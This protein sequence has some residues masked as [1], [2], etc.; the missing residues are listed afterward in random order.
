MKAIPLFRISIFVLLISF[1]IQGNRLPAQSDPGVEKAMI[2]IV[3]PPGLSVAVNSWVDA[4][5]VSNPGINFKVLA[6]GS[7]EA[8]NAVPDIRFNVKPAESVPGQDLIVARDMVV[9]IMHAG[10]PGT[11]RIDEKGITAAGLKEILLLGKNTTWGEIMSSVPVYYVSDPLVITSLKNYCG[12]TGNE[13]YGKGEATTPAVLARLKAEPAA[14]GICRFSELMSD[15]SSSTAQE[16]RL[17]PVDKNS[18]GKIDYFEQIYKNPEEFLRG[19]WIGKY[20]HALTVP[21]V[22]VLENN[23]SA[24][25]AG[26]IHWIQAGGQDLNASLG[27][28][29]ISSSERN[30]AGNLVEMP[31]IAPVASVAKND[32]FWFVFIGLILLAGVL[33][34]MFLRIRQV[35]FRNLAAEREQV[36]TM[37][38]E[39]AL[40]APK[41][42]FY[43]KTHTWSFM[44]QDGTV[45]MGIDDFLQHITGRLTRVKMKEVG[46]N[47]RKGE[48]ILTLVREGKQLEIYSPVSGVIRE[49]NEALLEDASAINTS[50]YQKGWIYAIEPINWSR[51]SGFMF[52]AEAYHDWLKKEFA[53][54]RD[55]FSSRSISGSLQPSFQ[56]IQDGGE[57]A[58]H[59][60]A[61]MGPEIW[62]D[63]QSEFIDTSR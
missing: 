28:C 48:K 18:N 35:R 56:I 57:M 21:I 25:K 3:C 14:I 58:D 63:F 23:P 1:T 41:G 53:R 43:D 49:C 60:L 40:R 11:K 16:I 47:I 31:E 4:Y 52:M 12:I 24:E 33:L 7:P 46:E 6:E 27:L 10:N 34:T 54:L 55:F 15:L 29:N 42:L 45:K 20:P 30:I 13:I 22:A 62:E 36:R 50:P 39:K 26:F 17:L 9:A 8:A 2:T 51:E 19:V 37:I 5:Q 59:L 44:E 32:T 61:D 38:S